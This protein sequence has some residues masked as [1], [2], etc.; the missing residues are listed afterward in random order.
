MDNLLFFLL[1]YAIVKIQKPVSRTVTVWWR[2]W[3][4]QHRDLV[5]KAPSGS[6]FVT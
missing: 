2:G 4:T 1:K 3:D 6:F 5:G